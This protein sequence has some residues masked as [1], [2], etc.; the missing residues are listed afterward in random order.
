MATLTESLQMQQAETGGISFD[1]GAWLRSTFLTPWTNTI[2]FIIL[3]AANVF[4]TRAAFRQWPI[5]AGIILVTWIIGLALVIRSELLHVWP[6]TVRW[7]KESM[8]TGP[9][10]TLVTL[11]LANVLMLAILGLLSWTVFNATFA[12]DPTL[13]R[14]IPHTGATWGVVGAN[15]RL[16]MVGRL[17]IVSM[18]RVYIMLATVILLAILSFLAW[19][20]TFQDRF[21]RWRAWMPWAWV[22]SFFWTIFL[23]N[24][25][26]R[27][28]R[29]LDLSQI[30]ATDAI[31]GL[32][33]LVVGTLI[34]RSLLGNRSQQ[35]RTIGY[36]IWAILFIAVFLQLA[37]ALPQR[38][39]LSPDLD[40]QF[41]QNFLPITEE[42]RAR[43]RLSY[44]E[45]VAQNNLQLSARESFKLRLASI[46]PRINTLLWGGLLLTIIIS[47]VGIVVSFPLGI[48]L[49]LGRRSNLPLVKL[50]CTVY[51]EAIRGV[52]LITILFMMIFML[53]LFLPEGQGNLDNV[54]RL[55]VGFVIFTAAYQ[56]ENVR[57]GL[58]AIPNGQYEAADAIGL[59]NYQKMRMIILPQALR[60]VIP[61]IVGLSIGLFKDTSLVA[62]VGTFDLLYTAQNITAQGDWLGL[63]KE[64]FLFAALIYWIFAYSMSYSSRRVERKLGVGVR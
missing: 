49:A 34:V 2:W 52:P 42:Q 55:M 1:F 7:L 24:G 38:S 4:I 28:V 41:E 5:I 11:A 19:S 25:F 9:F 50:V 43:D 10:G 23:L 62:I 13:A 21:K 27:T 47:V 37:G 26:S 3:V 53:P 51:I 32:G 63:R 36:T 14:E 6:G 45:F 58:Q 56:A 48:A 16:L 33:L 61:A 59:N 64:A 35:V 40:R 54:L 57:G 18:P 46:L 44:G 12:T 39:I 29:D 22:G 15:F 20:P 17:P 8:F 60:A 30:D 31:L